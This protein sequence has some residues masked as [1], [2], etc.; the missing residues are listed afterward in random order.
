M[1]ELGIYLKSSQNLTFSTP[2]YSL[3]RVRIR[4]SETLIFR[5]VSC[6]YLKVDIRYKTITSQN[7]TSEAQVKN[8]YIS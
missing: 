1:K 4:E 5:E 7:E 6:M 2:W 8:F 3:V